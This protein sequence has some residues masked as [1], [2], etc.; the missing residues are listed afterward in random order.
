MTTPESKVKEK[1]KALL[2]KHGAYYTLNVKV[3][4]GN[5]GDPDFDVCHAG[6]FAGVEAKAGKGKATQ[7]QIVRLKQIRA[8]GGAAF[9]INENTLYH[10]EAWL[11]DQQ[12]LFRNGNLAFL[13]IE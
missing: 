10:L 5:N 6:R 3:G 8:A 2:K 4:Y 11:E 13:G 1:I 12:S 7:L 9:I